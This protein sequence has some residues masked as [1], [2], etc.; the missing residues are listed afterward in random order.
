MNN[1]HC[2]RGSV[3]C[4]LGGKQFFWL[5]CPLAEDEKSHCVLFPSSVVGQARRQHLQL[6]LLS[7]HHPVPS[8]TRRLVPVFEMKS[9]PQTRL[10][11]SFSACC[12]PAVVLHDERIA[13]RTADI[14]QNDYSKYALFM[15]FPK[16][17][18]DIK[19]VFHVRNLAAKR[20]KNLTGNANFCSF[21]SSLLL[22][23]LLS[24]VNIWWGY[25]SHEVSKPLKSRALH[26]DT[27]VRQAIVTGKQCR[28]LADLAL[29]VFY[30]HR[31][32]C[33]RHATQIRCFTCHSALFKG[34]FV[35]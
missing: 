12:L 30:H 4:A 1:S 2:C 7:E 27:K 28:I 9:L 24:K 14:T 21:P 13:V 35:F 6:Q 17:L 8:G 31:V 15:K 10:F 22:C 5:F 33:S 34:R 20:S 3:H 11:S 26:D 25:I 19:S 29:C 18:C 23:K 32:Q 16:H